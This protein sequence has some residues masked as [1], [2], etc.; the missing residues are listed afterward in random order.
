MKKKL[1]VMFVRERFVSRSNI[2]EDS[3]LLKYDTV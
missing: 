3:R 2:D 1:S